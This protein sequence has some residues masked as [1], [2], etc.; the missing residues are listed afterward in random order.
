MT[1]KTPILNMPSNEI[2]LNPV[3]ILS[4]FGKQCREAVARYDANL[5]CIKLRDADT[6]DILHEIELSGNKNARDG[7]K[8][9]YKLKVVREDR[10]R[11]KVENEVLEPLVQWLAANKQT[12]NQLAQIQG[13]CGTKQRVVANRKYTPKGDI[14]DQ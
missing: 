4:D 10:R 14:L 13:K 12:M 1:G 3:P 2:R 5:E 9:Y 11:A 6:Q 7:Y 8:L